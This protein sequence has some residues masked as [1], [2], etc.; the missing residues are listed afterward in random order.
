MAAA[1]AAY[2]RIGTGRSVGGL[3]GLNDID[4]FKNRFKLGAAAFRTLYQLLVPF[5]HFGHYIEF[6]ITFPAFQIIKGH[7]ANLPTVLHSI[8]FIVYH[9]AAYS[10]NQVSSQY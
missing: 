1:A 2:M 9:M 3:S 6:F 8:V 4:A 5:T 7:L 10:R